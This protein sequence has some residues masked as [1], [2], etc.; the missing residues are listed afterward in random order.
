MPV[1]AVDKA[2]IEYRGYTS[3]RGSV[4]LDVVV[5]GQRRYRFGPFSNRQQRMV[6]LNNLRA[7]AARG[8][9]DDIHCDNAHGV[10]RQRARRDRLGGAAGDTLTK[11]KAREVIPGLASATD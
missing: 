6:L 11:E 2:K 8:G 5:N 4:M 1:A 3:A 9:T 10:R 7:P